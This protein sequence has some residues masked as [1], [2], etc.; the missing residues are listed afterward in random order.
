MLSDATRI[1]VHADH[2]NPPVIRA[3]LQD[4]PRSLVELLRQGTAWQQLEELL[5]LRGLRAKT[6]ERE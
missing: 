5:R 6:M 4:E 1:E 2:A 3:T